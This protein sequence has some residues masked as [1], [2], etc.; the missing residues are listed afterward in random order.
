MY[1]NNLVGD[2]KANPSDLYQSIT[3]NVFYP[4]KEEWKACCS[5]GP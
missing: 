1:V 4:E 3:P 5:I 2:V